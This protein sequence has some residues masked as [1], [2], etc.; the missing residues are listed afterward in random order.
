MDNATGWA[1]SAGLSRD[2]NALRRRRPNAALGGAVRQ[3][4]RT[5]IMRPPQ[6]ALLISAACTSF[7]LTAALP[8]TAAAA[9]DDARSVQVVMVNF[10]DS[11]FTDP[12]KSRTALKESYF[13]RTGSLTSYYNEVTKGAATFEPG[14][15]E[16]GV[17]G[18]VDVP[19]AA[20]GCDTGKIY[21][22]TLKQLEE[23]GLGWDDF[24]HLS[25]AFPGD[26]A[27][28][29]FGGLGSVGGGI[30]WLPVS[31]DGGGVDQTVLSHEFGHNFGY[32]HQ[33]RIPCSGTDLADCQESEGA[34]SRKTPMGGGT[35]SVGL[36]APE[37]LH[38]GWLSGK[39]AVKVTKSA[40]YTLNSLYGGQDRTRALDI[41][42]GEDRLVVEYRHASGTLDKRLQGVHAYRIPK[43]NYA[44]AE[45]IDMT[46]DADHSFDSGEP[47]ADSLAAGVTLTDK[48]NEV[49]VK[50]AKSG[51]PAATVAVSL[52]GVPAP[53][54][55]DTDGEQQ[56]EPQTEKTDP[57][58]SGEE[59]GSG[60]DDDSGLAET[61]ADSRLSTPL[62]AG[63][64]ALVALGGAFVFKSRRKRAPSGAHRAG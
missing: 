32:P 5:P 34:N 52:N 18:P 29:G 37:L 25:L 22:E 16:N 1:S 58:G 12:A 23:Q 53:A 45:M 62:M 41:P 39:E 49:Q 55:A 28:C 9:D 2:D 19:V 42:I 59:D 7:A 64:A 40:T 6:R 57:A 35:L 15:G 4:G 17:L 3:S 10:T 61:G 31:A 51:G 54:A 21:N 14:A 60:A 33:T 47:D 50:I 43:G 38:S 24:A 8:P 36:T 11:S 20:A 48:E 44:G 27:G 56:A 46:P 13:G 30:S 26:K 63:G